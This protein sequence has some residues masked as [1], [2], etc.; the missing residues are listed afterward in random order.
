MK[1]SMI[2]LVPTRAVARLVIGA[3]GHCVSFLALT[4][5]SGSLLAQ[6]NAPP[7]GRIPVHGR[8]PVTP[9]VIGGFAK[10]I[11]DNDDSDD[12][13]LN[14]N[15]ALPLPLGVKPRLPFGFVP[16]PVIL[17]GPVQ[18][19]LS[20]EGI[21]FLGSS[22]GCLPPDTGASVGNGF[23]VETVNVQLRVFDKITGAVLL[24]LPLAS[25]FGASTGGDPYVVY[26]DVA[27][28]WY[29]SAFNSNNSGLFLAVSVD[30]NPMD[31][32]LPTY[33][34]SGVGGHPDFEKMG[35][36]K[37]AIFLSYNDFGSGGGG[38]TIAAI[39]KAAALSGSLIYYVS[40]PQFQ[41]RAMPPA[42]MHGDTTGGVE[43]FVSTDGTD[44]GGNTIR[45]TRMQNY[46]S[47]SPTFDYTS[48]PVTQYLQASYAQQPGGTVDV[49]PNTTMTQVQYRNGHLV[50]AM[51]SGQVTDGF[52]YP[53]GLYYEIDVSGGTPT[54]L[55]QG[56]ID[57]G[58][59]VAVQM[60]SVDEDAR[61]NL[62]LTW[63]ESSASEFLSMWVG[64]VDRDGVLAA[65]VAAPGG[66]FFFA[67]S[68]IGDYSTLVTDPADGATFWAAN[69]YIGSDGDTDIWRTHITSF[70]LGMAVSTT[71]PANG[72]ILPVPPIEYTITFSA[73]YD[74]SAV[75]VGGVLVNGFAAASY[76]LIDDH[77]ISFKF[78]ANP[79]S[80]QGLQH[81]D[82]ASGTVKRLSDGNALEAYSSTF[83]YDILRMQVVSTTPGAGSVA[84]LPLTSLVVTLNQAYDQTS[85]SISDLA[86]SVGTVQSVQLVDAKTIKFLLAGITE[87]GILYFSLAAGAFTD[88]FGNPSLPYLANVTLDYGTEPFPV[89]VTALKPV[90]GMI[91]QTSF[92]GNIFPLGDTDTFTIQLDPGQT[93]TVIVE[94][95]D[96]SLQP[97]AIVSGDDDANASAT[98]LSPN[99]A[100]VI[101]TVST[102]RP[103]W[104]QAR[105]ATY[106]VTVGGAGESTGHYNVLLILNAA[107]EL[108]EYNG[109]SNDS[110]ATAQSLE[111][112]F[113]T[114][115]SQ[116]PKSE[117]GAVLGRSQAGPQPGDVF[118]SVRSFD[119]FGGS[120]R[121]YN[122]AGDL[123]QTI[124]SPE[125]DNGV[126]SDIELGPGNVI[127]VA[128]CTDF[129]SGGTVKGEVLK[130]DLRGKFL[131]SI[132]LPDDQADLG[133]FYPFGFDV[134]PDGTLWVPQ[135]NSGNVVQV[136]STGALLASYNVGLQP[137]DASVGGNGTV[138]ISYSDFNTGM[139]EVL[140]LDPTTG[141]LTT[142]VPATEGSPVEL[143][144]TADGGLWL[145]D[146]FDALKFDNIG[147][148]AQQIFEYPAL[149]AQPDP[150]GGP[151]IAAFYNGLA[152]YD[153]SGNFLF[154]RFPVDGVVVGVAVAG[155][156]SPDPLPQLL[157]DFYSFNLE[158][159]QIATVVL[160]LQEGSF[161]MAE[162]Q[163]AFG[164]VL[165]Q[166][167]ASKAADC[168]LTDFVA[169]VTGTYYIKVVGD[170]EYSVVV[171]RNADFGAGGN[172]SIGAAQ[173][174]IAPDPSTPHRVI[175]YVAS[176]NLDFSGGFASPVGLTA[177]GTALFMGYVAQLTQGSFDEAGSFFTT[178]RVGVGEFSTTF[179]FQITPATTPMA[180]GLTFCI[181]GNAPTELGPAG[182]GL[183]YGPA[184]PNPAVRGIRNSV[185]VKFDLYD[186]AGEGSNSTGL[187]TDG[188][189]P[190]IPEPGSPDV[191]VNLYG[192]GIDLTSQDVFRVD[193]VYDGIV[194]KV[195]I[196]DTITFATATQ[197]YTIDIP[198]QVRARTG[199]VG[200]TGGTSGLSS[201]QGIFA[202]TYTSSEP[203]ADFYRVQLVGNKKVR[204]ETSTPADGAG[205]F[206]NTLDP[207]LWL[208]DANGNLVATSDNDASDGRNAKISYKVPKGPGGTY[209]IA[210]APSP[211]SSQP[212][213]GEYIL[214][215]A[216]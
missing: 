120:I 23:V 1:Q 56:Q 151:W 164:N 107:A 21:D 19:S 205:Q 162:L 202:W 154:R 110:L 183:G 166:G 15:R 176:G 117:R 79:V 140:Q 46:L 83:R 30:A 50:T 51:A 47:S 208:Y 39:D 156:D 90:G 91:Y 157:A 74:P 138:F 172:S 104:A 49:S 130:F 121:R 29:V 4:A 9:S 43:W 192:T 78:G 87:E 167:I 105:P 70:P 180:D 123:E 161:A 119:L 186:N 73:P 65:S 134:A 177:N 37:D 59:G 69:E 203:L 86:V 7:P 28:R 185:A 131:G 45:V 189:S 53:K 76:T 128:L 89:P 147:Q 99:T 96:P 178:Y 190:T 3:R 159:G 181:Q 81:F 5:L 216:Q 24:D 133:Y 165:A 108:E 84:T 44:S 63:M 92:Q 95:A 115:D 111:S 80:N 188:R 170:A 152:K 146:V 40:N 195:T 62:G 191:V 194:L 149:D 141:N 67:S 98:A 75:N 173:P 122:S 11:G 8:K 210:I 145:G 155:I 100:A 118:A 135:P 148:L 182:G 101:Q 114:L 12:T 163:D 198:A 18:A 143:N 58:E 33:P 102:A 2:N 68:R 48:L 13:L 103:L 184:F 52:F 213:H 193:M 214:T 85:V 116:P 26:D 42:Q 171:T 14:Y 38:A 66:G 35:F 126:I 31:G 54:L 77:T 71:S 200:F 160:A 97:T 196:T 25:L 72:E 142:F 60:P 94:P 215:E 88:V 197:S 22:C 211:T 124:L 10:A 132:P 187:F 36:N 153:A 109:P 32:F 158:A 136:D 55:R 112:S 20:F 113:V 175:G 27:D 57:P 106:K 206:V 207:M 212:T 82:I 6:S 168:V 17:S 144:A 41:F 174:L 34:L 61:G 150:S 204:I 209:Y 169:N 93:M 127:Y 129:L 137:Q 199:F 201:I 139:S 16:S 179:T 125:F 64:S